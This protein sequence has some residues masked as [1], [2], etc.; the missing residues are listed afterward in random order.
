MSAQKLERCH[1]EFGLQGDRKHSGLNR[2]SFQQAFV[3]YRFDSSL[4]VC[5]D[6]NQCL[7]LMVD[8]IFLN[9]CEADEWNRTIP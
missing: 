2:L 6:K 8:V 7:T 3:T 5:C 4:S 9:V 1:T